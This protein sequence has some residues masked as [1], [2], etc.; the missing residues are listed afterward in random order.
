MRARFL[1]PCVAL[2]LLVTVSGAWAQSTPA[3]P[4]TDAQIIATLN[5]QAAN[6][7]AKAQFELGMDYQNGLDVPLDYPQAAI[8]FRKAA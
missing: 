7:D 3:I 1:G 2:A 5:E 6:G 8:W 4:P